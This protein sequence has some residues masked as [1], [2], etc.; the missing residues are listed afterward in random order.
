MNQQ[1]FISLV[2]YSGRNCP[3][4]VKVHPW[5]WSGMLKWLDKRKAEGQFNDINI[6]V[7]IPTFVRK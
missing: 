3:N 4:S 1:R 5:R 2:Y 7:G 6:G